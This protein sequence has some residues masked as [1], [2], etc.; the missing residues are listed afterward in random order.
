MIL[1]MHILNLH[2]CTLISALTA[3]MQGI[4]Y[5]YGGTSMRIV[6]MAGWLAPWVHHEVGS[7]HAWTFDVPTSP[8]A[9]VLR[10]ASF[11][12]ISIMIIPLFSFSLELYRI[13]SVGW[14]KY[15]YGSL[16]IPST[17]LPSLP[18]ATDRIHTHTHTHTTF[19]INIDHLLL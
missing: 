3:G 19:G 12:M 6:N 1:Q 15:I 11:M 7:S 2:T 16:Y 18:P 9:I 5:G 13:S 10:F 17:Y 8:F 4:F 14:R